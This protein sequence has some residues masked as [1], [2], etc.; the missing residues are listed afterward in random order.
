LAADLRAWLAPALP[1]RRRGQFAALALA[2]V[3]L[4]VSITL[5]VLRPPKDRSPDGWREWAR[6]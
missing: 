3:V 4:G 5:A 6:R 1:E 2:V